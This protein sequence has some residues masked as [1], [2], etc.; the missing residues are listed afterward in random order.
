MKNDYY[1]TNTIIVDINN[2]SSL[3]VYDPVKHIP[4]MKSVSQLSSDYSLYYQIIN[5]SLEFQ[6]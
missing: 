5:H 4:S 1:D 3:S 6:V 2:G